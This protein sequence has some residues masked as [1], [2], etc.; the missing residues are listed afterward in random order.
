L[1]WVLWALGWIY[2]VACLVL[3]LIFPSRSIHDRLAG[4]SLVPK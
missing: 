2:V 3:A 1:P 4:T